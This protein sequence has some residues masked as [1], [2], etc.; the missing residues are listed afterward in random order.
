MIKLLTETLMQLQ[1][2]RVQVHSFSARKQVTLF[3]SESAPEISFNGYRLT[4]DYHVYLDSLYRQCKSSL[5]D[6][7]N[8]S[9]NDSELLKKNIDLLRFEVREFKNRYFPKDNEQVLFNRVVFV[10]TPLSNINDDS[11]LKK[12]SQHISTSNF[13]SLRCLTNSFFIVSNIWKD[14]SPINV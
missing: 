5:E 13:S 3:E 7:I 8:A 6:Y 9:A 14:S 1:V 10:K 11:E 4:S 2:A 12:K